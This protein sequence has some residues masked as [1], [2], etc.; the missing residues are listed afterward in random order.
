MFIMEDFQ[1]L[2]DFGNLYNSSLV[3]SKG[4]GKKKSAARFNVMELEN[5]YV[6]KK[7]LV[8]HTYKI[9][10]YSEFIVSEPKRRVIKSGSHKDKV[11][12]HC[13]CDYVLLPKMKDIFIRDNYA[14]QINKGTLFGLNRL[15]EN[16]LDFYSKHGANGYVLKCDIT[17]FF[18]S[19]NHDVMKKY[20]RKYF[21]DEDIQWI[22]NLF[23][24]SVDGDGLPLG[25]QTSQVF[26]LIYLT[27]LDYF[28]TEELHCEY[29]GRYMDDFYL[30]SEDKEYLQDCLKKITEY[31]AGL[32][33][34]LNNKTEIVP[35]SKGIRFIGFHTYVTDDGKVIRKLT[36]E[37]KRKIK[38]RLR[39]Y[40]KLVLNGSMTK[41][42]YRESYNAWRNHASHGNCFKLI[43]D[44]DI[45]AD[46]LI[47]ETKKEARIIVCGSRTF[48]DY[49]YLRKCLDD[50]IKSNPGYRITIV[51]GTAA[52]ADKLGEQY[53]LNKYLLLKRFPAKWNVYGKS[54]GYIRNAEMLDYAMSDDAEPFV[55]A[56]WDGES[57]GTK[58]MI[59]L[60]KSKNVKT[61]IHKIEVA[62]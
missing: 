19:I 56:F 24:D 49:V 28:I 55:M 34:T 50:F 37:N 44:M 22:C 10:P 43:Y 31:L 54:A 47:G 8:S 60:A 2:I 35:I 16:M 52:G 3:S 32:K 57:H 58:Q 51:S 12:Q 45:F 61:I 62:K 15:S 11:L 40:A 6:M 36:G 38:K 7:Q 29:Y 20:I 59:K 4:K 27:G 5:L 30:I 41:E 46:E 21:D 1:K 9:S 13:L 18:Y 53:A 33:L 39:K 25:N 23:I 14:G 42:K 48:N 26:A 17:K